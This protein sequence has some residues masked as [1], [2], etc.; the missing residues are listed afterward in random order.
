MNYQE[1]TKEQ[2]IAEVQKLQQE[3]I[4]LKAFYENEIENSRQN[5]I[6]LQMSEA[7]FR[8]YFDLPFI[9][10]AITSPDKGWI[11][12]NE[13]IRDLL[14]YSMDELSSLTWAELT[15]P[16][17]LLADEEQF[18]KV[19]ADQ[20]DIYFLEKRFIRKNGEIIWTN[21][22]LGCVRKPDRSVDY[23]IALLQDISKRKQ[24][25]KE[26]KKSEFELKRAQQ[27]THIGSFYIDLTTN[28]VT[29]TEE[30]SLVGT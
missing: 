7:R 11:E 15:H 3:N 22:S 29:W 14:G 24:A 4:S 2:L 9:G 28:Q 19:I 20:Q 26:L 25:E 12:A 30:L 16:D 21:L 17:D 18:N 13:G 23:M 27:I 5:E 8:S 1:K 10:I 6:K